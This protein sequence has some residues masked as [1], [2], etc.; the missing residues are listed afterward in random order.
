[1]KGSSV[2]HINYPDI[3]ETNFS[4]NIPSKKYNVINAANRFPN[5]NDNESLD[6]P[7]EV[8]YVYEAK[9]FSRMI[10]LPNINIP[11]GYKAVVKITQ[12]PIGTKMDNAFFVENDSFEN[13]LAYRIIELE[14]K[15]KKVNQDNNSMVKELLSLQDMLD[16]MDKKEGKV[17]T[18]HDKLVSKRNKFEKFTFTFG[19][20]MSLFLVLL[21]LISGLNYSVVLPSL[22]IFLSLPVFIKLR[23]KLR[24]DHYEH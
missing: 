15:L 14:N 16:S 20:V 1:M 10:S 22:I 9:E 13:S 2:T 5:S 17:M 3:S 7:E 11:K 8:Q 24:G 6:V 21:P 19:L 4:E 23:I 12:E 18:Y